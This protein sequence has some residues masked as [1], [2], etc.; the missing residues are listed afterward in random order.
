MNI[1]IEKNIPLEDRKPRA[2]VLDLPAAGAA[3]GE[4]RDLFG[5]SQLVARAGFAGAGGEGG[6]SLPLEWAPDGAGLA[7]L[8]DESRWP[9]AGEAATINTKS[10]RRSARKAA[11]EGTAS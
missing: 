4:P 7:G 3:P 10:A 2:M 6:D 8:A 5:T 1:T 9:A 11:E